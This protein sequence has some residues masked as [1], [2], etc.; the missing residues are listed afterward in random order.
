MGGGGPVA[1][2]RGGRR[3]GPGADGVQSGGARSRPAAAGAGQVTWHAG[4][5]DEVEEVGWGEP[6]L[7]HC[8]GP[9]QRNSNIFALFKLISIEL[10]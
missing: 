3:R 8:H 9:A 1:A 6:L 7:G 5:G 2:A 10:T 4:G